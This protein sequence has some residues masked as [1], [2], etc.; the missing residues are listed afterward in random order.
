[1]S[2]SRDLSALHSTCKRAR[3]Y[4]AIYFFHKS[5]APSICQIY[6]PVRAE[7]KPIARP[8]RLVRNARQHPLAPPPYCSTPTATGHRT[9]RLRRYYVWPTCA[10]MRKKIV[11]TRFPRL[12]RRSG[13][14][15]GEGAPPQMLAPMSR[16]NPSFPPRIISTNCNLILFSHSLTSIRS[17]PSLYSNRTSIHSLQS[18]AFTPSFTT[19]DDRVCLSFPLHRTQTPS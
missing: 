19:S 9:K 12:M 13:S 5:N 2:R 17:L 7:Q 15:S 1:M 3:G 16:C 4:G 11:A 10:K 6:R 18:F 14:H 8:R